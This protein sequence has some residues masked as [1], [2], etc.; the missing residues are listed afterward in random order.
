MTCVSRRRLFV[1]ALA[2]WTL[3]FG[4]WNIGTR[5]DG[6]ETAPLAPGF[7]RFHAEGK[8]A[9]TGGELLLGELNCTSCHALD[10]AASAR[11]SPKRAPLLETL[12]TRVRPE[13]V[14]EFLTNPQHTKGGTTMP[15]PFVGWSAEEKKSAIEAL[16]HYLALSGVP[17]DQRI[18]PSAI[19]KGQ[20]LFHSVGCAACHNPQE[21]GAA[22]LSTSV[23]LGNLGAKYTLP[24]LSSFIQNP[25]AVRPSGRMPSLNLTNDEARDIASYLLR[26]LKNLRLPAN[27][28]YVYY[29]G[30]WEALPD[31]ATL[32]PQATGETYGFGLDFTPSK[33]HF[34]VRFHGI[35]Q[36]PKDGDYTFHLGSDDGS[37]L[38]IDGRVVVENDGIH[39][40]T[41][42]QDHV[43][44]TAGQ[45]P[46][47]VDFFE[48]AGGEELHVEIEAN[49][50]PRQPLENLLVTEKLPE[51]DERP[52]FV[53]DSSLADQGKRLFASVGCAACHTPD[54]ADAVAKLNAPA[55][56]DLKTS[57]GCLSDAPRKGVPNYS[58]NAAQRT[59]LAAGIAA[60]RQPAELSNEQ[61]IART[62]ETFNCYACHQRGDVGGVEDARDAFFLTTQKEMGDEGRLPPPLSGVGA[63]LTPAYFKTLF[64][65]APKERPYMHTRMPRFGLDNV[66]Q[67][68][69]ALG[70]ADPQPPLKE[71]KHELPE[72]AMK[73]GGYTL[74]GAKGFS[75]I[76]CH[77]WGNV[78]ATGIQ[79]IDMQRMTTRL[80]Q[81]WFEAYLLDPQAF[82]PGTRMPGAWPEGQV[83]LPK[84]LDG[85]ASTQIRAVWEFLADGKDA[86]IPL[87]LGRDPIELVADTEA[88][89][90]RNFIEGAGPRAIGVGYPEHVNLAFDANNLNMALIWQG[91]FIDASK[92]WVDRGVGFQSPLGDNVLKLVEGVPLATLADANDAWPNA[93]GKEMGYRFRGYRLDKLRRPT[94]LYSFGEVDVTEAWLPVQEQDRVIFRRTWTFAS[95]QPVP[96]LFA[97]V[98]ASQEMKALGEGKYAC[99]EDWSTRVQSDSGQPLLRSQGNRA[100]LLVPIE[101]KNGKATIVQDFIW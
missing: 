51:T 18:V 71:I 85:Q 50:L 7:E 81:A 72:R 21:A 68:V 37:R 56:A 75:C 32:Q 54:K 23:P 59:A 47:E 86:R 53:V 62:L 39:G 89:M 82:R 60:L 28:Q 8:N 90:Y 87:G 19:S 5:A 6:A 80:N 63:K 25:H 42:K 58:L 69:A 78:Q 4:G 74:V 24:G 95:Q 64:D 55:L 3:I 9:D 20:Q 31:F 101:F 38:S 41:F 43:K 33:D 73:H 45:H 100:E 92:H 40:T 26:D 98:A 65:Q 46:L 13:Y 14:R 27:L 67:L 30:S 91:A 29:E 70:A 61:Q 88:I 1:F 52:P 93:T 35:I 10:D 16:T 22:E 15:D 77:T 99:A 2:I 97:R 36:L 94:F 34:A 57:G 11:V 76:K 17:S 79:S 12:G 44:L 66:G 83:Q 84:L 96:H 48:A 49:G